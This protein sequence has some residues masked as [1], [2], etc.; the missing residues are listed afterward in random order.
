VK[1]SKEISVRVGEDGLIV[2]R[3]PTNAEWNEFNNSQLV[4][5]KKGRM[6]FRINEAREKLFD[7]LLVKI[8]NIED[9]DGPITVETR[10]RLPSRFKSRVI[11]E[12]FELDEI[13]VK[14]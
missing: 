10:E 9:A 4:P 8:E 7:T 3:E 14:N 11:I 2:L 6:S 5:G 12:A 13:D 1:L